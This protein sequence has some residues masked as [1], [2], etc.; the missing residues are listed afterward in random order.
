M[1]IAS[2]KLF[3]FPDTAKMI[4]LPFSA[5]T[6]FP[7]GWKLGD[8]LRDRSGRNEKDTV[9]ASCDLRQD[10]AGLGVVLVCLELRAQ[11]LQEAARE[12]TARASV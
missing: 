1:L 12:R 5:M 2:R 11:E 4:S 9:A 6:K 3:R 10:D 7:I 8:Y